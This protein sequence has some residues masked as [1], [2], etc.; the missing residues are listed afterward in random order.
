MEKPINLYN[1]EGQLT[2]E[3][4]ALKQSLGERDGYTPPEDDWEGMNALTDE[5]KKQ[6]K[7]INWSQQLGNVDEENATVTHEKL[8][9]KS[10]KPNWNEVIRT[11]EL[12]DFEKSLGD[13]MNKNP[14]GR[15]DIPVTTRR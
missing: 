1:D 4:K 14:K 13:Y 12:D 6:G 3:M 15:D 8:P 10:S 11:D 2:D 9:M 5:L 7:K